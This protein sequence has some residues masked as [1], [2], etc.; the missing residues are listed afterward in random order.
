MGREDER[1]VM[2][3]IDHLTEEKVDIPARE[4]EDIAEQE[5][6]ENPREVIERLKEQGLVAEEH[7]HVNKIAKRLFW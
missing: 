6:V 2:R 7:G 3:I 1:T 4:I 5:G